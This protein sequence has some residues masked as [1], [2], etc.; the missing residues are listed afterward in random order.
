MEGGHV[1]T[2]LPLRMHQLRLFWS[3]WCWPGGPDWAAA[4]H[5]TPYS[6]SFINHFSNIC[7]NC[8]NYLQ[9]FVHINPKWFQTPLTVFS[10]Q[11]KLLLFCKHSFHD[12]S[13]EVALPMYLLDF[14]PQRK[15]KAQG[16]IR[17]A[18]WSQVCLAHVF[19]DCAWAPYKHASNTDLLDH[20]T[21]KWS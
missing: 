12:R 21:K 17:Y 2:A 6:R 18:L 9:S 10:I 3:P 11:I 8:L 19:W 14:T 15:K 16:V 7:L 1:C 5:A 20:W 13:N 4:T